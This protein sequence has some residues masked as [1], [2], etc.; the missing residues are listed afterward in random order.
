MRIT[1]VTLV[2]FC[3]TSL[4][5][6][7][8]FLDKYEKQFPSSVDYQNIEITEEARQIFANS[9]QSPPRPFIHINANP[10]YF[11]KAL[12]KHALTPSFD[13]KTGKV[14]A[15]HGEIPSL[16]HIKSHTER[17]IKYLEEVKGLYNISD[18][19][20]E[21][22][23]GESITDDRH[24]IHTKLDQIHNGIKVYGG[25]LTL[26]EKDNNIYMIQGKTRTIAETVDV[27]PKISKDEIAK[28]VI[29]SVENYEPIPAHILP[30]FQHEQ[31]TAELM[32][33]PQDANHI[34]VCKVDVFP[35]IAD[36]ETL[37]MD[38]SDGRILDRFKIICKFHD[39]SAEAFF[40]GKVSSTAV[41]LAGTRRA[42]N[43]F[44]C[45]SD[46]I[47][48]DASKSMFRGVQS[49]CADL[50]RVI[51]GVILTLNAGNTSP[52]NSNFDYD[53]TSS[54][55]VDS[56]ADRSAISA[57]INGSRAYEYFKNTFGR[58]SITGNGSN[59]ISFVNVTESDGS[60]MDNAFW[61]GE[62][63]FY[64]NGNQA[65]T[66]PLAGALDVA[67]HE[68]SHGV[69]QTSANL[70]YRNEAGALNEHFADVFGVLIEREDFRIGE[71][72]ANP[73]IFRS[74][75]IRSMQDP[76]N[77]GT[78]L[79]DPGYQPANTSEQFFGEEDNGGVHINSG[80]PNLAFFTLVSDESFGADINERAAIGE[81]IWYK[82]LTQFLRST[83]NFSDLRIA[84][85]QAARE[86]YGQVV[87]SAVANAFDQVGISGDN[88]TPEVQ[89]LETNPGDEFVVW[90]DLNFN[91]IK[92]STSD[93]V[94]FGVLS[95]TSHISR[96]SAT[97]NGQFVIFVNE[98]KQIQ[99]VE[100]DWSI[101]EVTRDFLV[102]ED[103]VYRNAVVSRDGSKI[104][105]LTG[106]LAAGDFDNSII[107]FDL[108]G[109][110]TQ[111]YELFN[112]TFSENNSSIGGVSYADVLEFDLTGEN[113]IYDAFNELSS[114]FGQDL[115]YWDIG[116]INIWNNAEDRFALGNIFK[117]F[118]GLPE[119][120]SIGNP[121]FSK[122][123][124]NIIAF[125]FLETDPN[126][127]EI[128][129]SILGFNRETGDLKTIFENNTVGYP[130]YSIQDDQLI[131]SVENNGSQILAIT[132]LESD[133][134]SAS[135][136]A[137][138]FIENAEWGVFLGNGSRNLSTATEEENRINQ[139]LVIYPNPAADKIF[140]EV[141]DPSIKETRL[142]L[143]NMQGQKIKE[144]L[145]YSKD[146]V[147]IADLLRGTYIIKY[148]LG[149][150]HVFRKF[151][152]L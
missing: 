144:K 93:G 3:W 147:G 109:G 133:K 14:I 50:D 78:S 31:I 114:T 7:N 99:A 143:Y 106:D 85:I 117:L 40:D 146:E 91:T 122:N 74:G 120:V 95:E 68:M 17:C 61:N 126:T 135:G 11:N 53:L 26:H 94:D 137:F 82:A 92:I 119:D 44:Q 97:D 112:P 138:V 149:K 103:Q 71:D 148:S 69:I 64:G 145:V 83:S 118:S 34:L 131:F 19:T 49:S 6:Q 32:I 56:W 54:R 75:A 73:Q 10:N 21:I 80:I 72:V 36:R 27:N 81:Q 113:I 110:T 30:L 98:F 5:S 25:E 104:A 125:D 45:G 79:G 100:I 37:I 29:R 134:I 46:Y 101:P 16:K 151:V 2:F 38:A 130:S 65:F 55:V 41:D 1:A 86:D 142:T 128:S 123:S 57:H 13:R 136:D 35:N 33:Y 52:E 20:K 70:E 140:V 15:I 24:R 129:F 121:T 62:F 59:I 42:I 139:E 60:D 43:I 51:D 28:I 67:G 90:S 22:R 48:L 58:E 152:K 39:H 12:V 8:K 84:T 96:P 23:L 108:D 127:N 66:A 141:N 18:P 47:L 76:H 63:I 88:V 89:D 111:E 132:D 124:P 102:S 116:I 105:A 9:I 107:V 77:G 4:S 87:A 150:S 115:S